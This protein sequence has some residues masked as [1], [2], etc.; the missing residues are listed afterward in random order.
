MFESRYHTVPANADN[1]GTCSAGLC[2]IRIPDDSS[3]AQERLSVLFFI[4]MMWCL[5]PFG[6]QAFAI[7]EKRFFILDS[8]KGLY[9]PS[10]YF[11]SYVLSSKAL[12]NK[13]ATKAQSSL[14]QLLLLLRFVGLLS[15][16]K[17]G[18]QQIAPQ[19]KGKSCHFSVTG[20]PPLL[21]FKFQEL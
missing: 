21:V 7:S 15:S 1:E 5:Q 19:S 14:L 3:S 2:W 12:H 6:W 10:A 11:V 17:S 16:R 8:A 13:I 20:F 18:G 4:V 9:S